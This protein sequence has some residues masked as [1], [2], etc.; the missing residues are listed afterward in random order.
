MVKIGQFWKCLAIWSCDDTIGFRLS[1]RSR[2]CRRL[3]VRWVNGDYFVVKKIL[4]INFTIFFCI[5]DAAVD[6]IE[7]ENGACPLEVSCDFEEDYCGFYNT[8]EGDDIDWERGKGQLYSTT[9]PSA[10]HT[11]Q[12][13][14]GYY[15]F[16][17]P[18]S[19]MVVGK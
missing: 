1:S 8:K 7:I 11:T 13:A 6:D 17:N 18:L 2:R 19:P 5:R 12:T 3:F 14:L 4:K 9:G 10:D 16:I 15:A